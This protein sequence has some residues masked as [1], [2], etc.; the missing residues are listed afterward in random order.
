MTT[1]IGSLP[2][3]EPEKACKL[4]LDTF[5]IP[6]WPQLPKLSFRESMIP[7]FSEGMPFIKIDERKETIWIERNRSDAL[8][9]F[10]ETY[11]EDWKV[12]ISESYAK[13][14]YTFIGLLKNKRLKTLKGQITGPLT[15]SLG[16]K[17]SV[18]RPVYFDEELREISLMLLKAKIRWQI[19]ILKPYG[20]EIIIFIDEPILSALGSTSYIGVDPEETLRLLREITDAIKNAGG[21]PGIH[22]CGKAD[23]PLVINSDIRIISFDAYEYIETISMYPAEFTEFFKG[24][25]YLA[26]GIIPTTDSI[27]EESLDSIKRRFDNSVDRLSKSIPATL[28]LSQIMLTPSCG[29]GSK[30][31]EETLKVFKTLVELKGLIKGS[32]L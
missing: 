16:L 20:E 23:W 4:V 12:A 6:F 25:G 17:D 32:S 21:I 2:Y 27:R 13:G 28:L 18:G 29:T 30:S 26:W 15:F 11:S 22:C 31:I 5:D 7:Q 19:E 8:T 24:G 3:T 14:L 1:G 9:R 10:Y